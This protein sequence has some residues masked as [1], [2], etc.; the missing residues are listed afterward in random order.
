[1]CYCKPVVKR[2]LPD[3]HNRCLNC[4]GLFDDVGT[5]ESEKRRQVQIDR[6][7]RE[8]EGA[9]RTNQGSRSIER[10]FNYSESSSGSSSTQFFQ[11]QPHIVEPKSVVEQEKTTTS[12]EKTR[13]KSPKTTILMVVGSAVSL[14]GGVALLAYLLF[15]K[16]KGGRYD[17]S[18]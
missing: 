14:V 11:Q 17:T 5:E 16:K 4:G 1:M 13:N 2:F 9:C 8:Q 10:E 15:R 12:Y 6:V 18:N 7:K 3:D